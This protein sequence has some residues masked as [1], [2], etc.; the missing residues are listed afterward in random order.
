MKKVPQVYIENL[1][2]Y[3]KNYK[4]ENDDFYSGNMVFHEEIE[5][6]LGELYHYNNF[7]HNEKGLYNFNLFYSIL[8]N[9]YEGGYPL[10]ISVATVAD[11]K[12]YP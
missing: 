12:N 5:A 7:R 9:N 1:T 8:K 4:L 6:F 11:Q 10:Y 2:E 3:L